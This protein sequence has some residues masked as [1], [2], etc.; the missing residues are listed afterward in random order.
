MSL[1]ISSYPE[2]TVSTFVLRKN[3]LEP[4]SIF[5]RKSLRS[6]LKLSKTAANCALFFLCGELPIEGKLH[7]DVFSLLYSIWSNPDTKI[8]QVVKYL[9]SNSC[10]NSGTW[11]VFVKQLSRMYSMED[12][13]KC[14]EQDPPLKSQFKEHVITK[15]T[16]FHESELRELAKGNSCME[17]LNVSVTGLRGRHHP[18]I[19][20][21][22]TTED[23]KL[24]R[25]HIK[26][27]SGDF[28]TY[29]KKSTQSGGSPHCRVCGDPS[30]NE[31]IFHILITCSAYI[32]KCANFCLIPQA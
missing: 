9:M 17:Y 26:M 27:L 15:I 16:A 11:S 14:L 21:L 24:S 31:T 19:S 1:K 5:Q 3:T 29:Q 30:E 2:L 8:Y 25:S 28:F 10:D 32:K 23:V 6:I 20:G 18:A 7:R 22:I 4:I 12:P 13:V